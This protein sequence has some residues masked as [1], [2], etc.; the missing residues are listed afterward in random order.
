MCAMIPML[1]T[2]ARSVSTSRATENPCSRIVRVV[3]GRRCRT[4]DQPAPWSFT[5][6][7]SPAVVRE[8]LV[9][10]GHLVGVLAPLDARTQA[11]ARVEQFVGQPVD[12]GLLPAGLGEVHQPAQSQRGGP[13]GADLD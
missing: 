3:V 6:W 12:H 10:L 1:L 13:A 2:L 5:G 7:P 8:C 11:V 9:G 4:G